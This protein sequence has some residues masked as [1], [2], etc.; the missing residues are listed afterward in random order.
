MY[1]KSKLPCAE[2][3]AASIPLGVFFRGRKACSMSG[4]LGVELFHTDKDRAVS[5]PGNQSTMLSQVR[6]VVN[7]GSAS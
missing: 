5:L 1:N 3:E 6:H 2:M 4:L 7:Q